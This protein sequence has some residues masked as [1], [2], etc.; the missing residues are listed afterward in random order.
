ML[1]PETI[2]KVYHSLSDSQLQKLVKEELD[3]LTPLAIQL[4]QDEFKLRKIDF[5]EWGD[6]STEEP[7]YIP[8]KLNASYNIFKLILDQTE[9]DLPG[10]KIIETLLEQGFPKKEISETITALPVFFQEDIQQKTN[11]LLTGTVLF[12]SGV[13]ILFL[14]ISIETHRVLIILAYCAIITGFFRW[15]HALFYKKRFMRL[16]LKTD[17]LFSTNELE[18]LALPSGEE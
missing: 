18:M 12:I 4:L 11:Q 2:K 13:A 1:N 7:N 15:M 8:S 10:T 16:K 3:Q 17:S 5:K 6:A 9:K 14:P